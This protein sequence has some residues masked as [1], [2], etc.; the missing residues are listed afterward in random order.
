MELKL[1]GAALASLEV[2]PASCSTST[3]GPVGVMPAAP[4]QKAS[5]SQLFFLLWAAVWGPLKPVS[6]GSSL[7]SADV[8]GSE[9]DILQEEWLVKSSCSCPLPSTD[10]QDT[11]RLPG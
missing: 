1:E 5:T 7:G 4:T 2:G 9:G 6:L 8:C 3:P 10:P 11:A